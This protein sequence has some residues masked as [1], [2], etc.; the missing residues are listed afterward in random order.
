[1]A[2]DNITV[3]W[4]CNFCQKTA[5]VSASSNG[6]F[7]LPQGWEQ[8]TLLGQHK[9]AVEAKDLRY[10]R[11]EAALESDVVELCRACS[12]V[13]WQHLDELLNLSRDFW[14]SRVRFIALGEAPRN[15]GKLQEVEVKQP[16]IQSAGPS[17]QFNPQRA[18][19][20]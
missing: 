13:Y 1:M 10:S 15:T 6:K 12:S 5:S 14:W 17:I 9:F 8:V 3:E 19:D 11:S 20:L 7:S 4:R 18:L 16:K 2:I